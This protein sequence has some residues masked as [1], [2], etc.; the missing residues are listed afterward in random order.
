MAGLGP[1][2]H[3]GRNRWPMPR[4]RRPPIFALNVSW[5][6]SLLQMVIP[7]PQDRY[8]AT[9][10]IKLRY[11][12]TVPCASAQKT[13]IISVTR[14]AEESKRKAD[15]NRSPATWRESQSVFLIKWPNA[16][17]GAKKKGLAMT[18]LFSDPLF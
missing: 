3:P 2:P 8:D 14:F 18:L 9:G 12:T 6:I 16:E 11:Y 1:G 13:C 7:S 15:E 10:F 17:T 5:G 4:D